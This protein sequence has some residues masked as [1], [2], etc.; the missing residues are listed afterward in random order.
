VTIRGISF[1]Y[2]ITLQIKNPGGG[3]EPVVSESGVFFDA[4]TIDE[5]RMF[6][7]TLLAATSQPSITSLV[8]PS[9]DPNLSKFSVLFYHCAPNEGV[10]FLERRNP[11]TS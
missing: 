9:G 2:L 6:R 8:K 1:F 11:S 7:N 3:H 4:E 5:Q 10:A